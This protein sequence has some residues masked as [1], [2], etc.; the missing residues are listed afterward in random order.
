MS[1]MHP[2]G[3]TRT[4]TCK[5]TMQGGGGGLLAGD[6]LGARPFA[7]ARGLADVRGD[8]A[9]PMVVSNVCGA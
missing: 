6:V 8:A 2:A 1:C 7:E 9:S 4:P 3:T 5:Q